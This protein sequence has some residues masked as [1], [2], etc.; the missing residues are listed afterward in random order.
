MTDTVDTLDAPDTVQPVA[1][2]ASSVTTPPSAATP[3][4]TA[5]ATTSAPAAS[6]LASGPT[7][8]SGS[9]SE[10]L[11]IAAGMVAGLVDTLWAARSAGELLATVRAVEGLRSVLDAVQLQV[12]VEVDARGAA[13]G[14]G[15]ASTKD[16][17][18]AVTGGRL[19]E[20]RRLLALAKAV[21]S[22]RAGTGAAL[23]V[24][25]I[26]RA[27]AEAVVG[28]VDRLPANPGLR[29]AAEDLL[30]AE[31]RTRDASELAKLGHY[32]LERLDPD[33][34]ERR[35]EQALERQERAAHSGRFLSVTPD[36]IG[37]V[38]LK[39][40]GT[41]EDAARISA[42]LAP[43]A[44]PRPSTDP[45][46][47]GGTPSRTN[48]PGDDSHDRTHGGTRRRAGRSCGVVDC[49]H[50]GRDPREHGTRMWDALV[51]AARL[52]ATTEVLP[53][54]HGTPTRVGVTIDLD[55]LRSSTGTGTLDMGGTLSAAAVRTLAC[56]AEILPFV[57][58]SKSQPL[59]VG[60]TSRLVTLALWLTLIVRDRHCAFPGCTRPPNACDAHHIDHW[61][62]GGST[63]LHNLVL[64]CRTHHTMIHTTDWQV[65]LH[66]DDQHPDFYPPTTLDPHQHPLR[67][68]P[69]RGRPNRSSSPPP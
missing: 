34:T 15:W 28:V 12:V 45:G 26:S 27:Q 14:E 1:P 67:R 40:R 19:G 65:R 59:D 60:R 13:Q 10:V 42:V 52:L 7:P 5:F 33:G 30:L 68:R 49:A 54:S 47:C 9:A 4:P 29:S 63:A 3:L 44:T 46:S 16:Y 43:L 18:S 57:L 32:V 51:E 23:A 11:G 8:V 53:H 50:D 17:L 64:L 24:G 35:D 25:D 6:G 37:G 58:G 66:P 69:L 21:H 36:G 39:G 56:D 41:L 20:G 62:N 2:A 31:A 48:T 22:D 61:A 38:R 55:A